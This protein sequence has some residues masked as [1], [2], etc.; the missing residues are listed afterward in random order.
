[1]PLDSGFRRNDQKGGRPKF[2]SPAKAGIQSRDL[3]MPDP[4]I[5]NVSL[6][7]S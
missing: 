6:V 7:T 5:D 2:V 3:K 4:Q 1:M